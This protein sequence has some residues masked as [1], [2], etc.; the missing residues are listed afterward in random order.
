VSARRV[1]DLD[2]DEIERWFEARNHKMPHKYFFPKIGFIVDNIA[3]GFI[4]MTDSNV[5]IID[6]YISNPSIDGLVRGHALDEITQEL[7]KSAQFYGLK[8]IKCDT[9]LEKVKNRALSFGFKH[10]GA[11]ESFILEL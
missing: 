9:K 4:Y 1:V 7:I 2:F 8:L 10:I 6:V 5:G 11:Y 3:A